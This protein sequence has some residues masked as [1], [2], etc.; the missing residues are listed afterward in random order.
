MTTL[1]Q[2]RHPVDTELDVSSVEFWCSDFDARERVFARLRA[3][4]PVSW[5]APLATPGLPRRFRE[6]GFWAVTTVEDVAFVSR[7]HALFSSQSGQVSL[8]PTPFKLDRNMLVLDPPDHRRYRRI[9]SG[10]FTPKRVASLEPVIARR[11]RQIVL[12]AR[13]QEQFDLVPTI[14]ARL[15]LQT[16]ADLLGIPEVERGRFVEA[17]DTYAGTAIPAAGGTGAGPRSFVVQHGE[18]LRELTWAL[19]A[20]RR[21]RPADDLI[22]HL[23]NDD[24]DGAPLTDAEILSAV[25]LLI[26][27]G[28]DTTKQAIT[29]AVLALHRNPDQR[30]WLAADFDG[31]F[32][33]AFDE[34]VRYTS[35]VLSFARTAT[36][37]VE[38]RGRLIAAGDKVALFYCSAN[39]DERV[40]DHP[41]RLD[42]AREP[43]RHVGFGG[44]GV[45]FCLGAA[46]ARQQLKAIIREI[47]TRLPNLDIGT[48]TFRVSEFIH[49]VDALPARRGAR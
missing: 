33:R 20:E 41:E 43:N 16:L 37:D 25:L 22:S 26:V 7:N 9:V 24:Q 42:L 4:A 17:A 34:L 38:L 27:A 6:A 11:A 8:R 28:D 29:L 21:R 15:P 12:Q 18:Y 48:P 40:F 14:A 32:D 3:E 47:L 10:A 35:P 46:I 44:G 5:H 1:H 2:T 39:R 49:A 45:H 31:R 13:T 19:V 36:R 23:A 30:A